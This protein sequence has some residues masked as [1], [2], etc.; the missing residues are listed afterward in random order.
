MST[1]R[2]V[3]KLNRKYPPYK[4]VLLIRNDP[5]DWFLKMEDDGVRP[6]S[7]FCKKLHFNDLGF[8]KSINN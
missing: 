3:F 4:R 6:D 1:K 2:L 5:H 7:D 8:S